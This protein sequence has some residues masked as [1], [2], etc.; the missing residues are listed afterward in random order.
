MT[1]KGVAVGAGRRKQAS[2][3]A[4]KAVSGRQTATTQCVR[5]VA[6]VRH[7]CG[8]DD[9]GIRQPAYPLFVLYKKT[10]QPATAGLNTSRHDIKSKQASR[11]RHDGAAWTEPDRVLRAFSPDDRPVDESRAAITRVRQGERSRAQT[12]ARVPGRRAA[13]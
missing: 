9:I 1:A 12:Y 13:A 10:F 6:A 3:D 5:C 8:R 4:A 2:A 11:H 7:V